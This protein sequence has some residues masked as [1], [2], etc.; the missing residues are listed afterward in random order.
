M[1]LSERWEQWG[2]A[3]RYAL[4]LGHRGDK[5]PCLPQRDPEPNRRS[6]ELSIIRAFYGY[7][8]PDAAENPLLPIAVA[9]KFPVYEN[10]GPAWGVP[11]LPMFLRAFVDTEVKKLWFDLRGLFGPVDKMQAF[12]DLFSRE[13]PPPPEVRDWMRD[14]VFARN[15]VD[16]PNPLLLGRVRDAA[17]LQRAVGI[18][19]DEFQSVMGRG[20]TL[21]DELAAGNLFVADFWLLQHSLLPSTPNQRD[22]RWRRKYLPSP[23]A[24]FC[25]RPGFDPMCD[26]APVAIRI[27]QLNSAPP[28]PL[29]LRSDD[30]RWLTAK[31]YVEVAEFNLQAMSSHI[32]RHHYLAEPFAVTTRRQL[33]PSHPVYVL[34]EPHLA[35]TLA[36]NHS[37]FNLLKQPGSIFDEIY[38]GEL[39]ETRNIMIESYAHWTFGDQALERDLHARGVENGPVDYPYRDDARL[40]MPVIERFVH[41]YLALY[42]Q[43]I[44]DVSS[45]W[46]LQAWA[47]EL[48]AR[49]GGN[50]R[51]LFG[52]ERIATVTELAAVLGQFLF[53]AGPGHAAVHYP[54]T[55]YF[56]YVPAFPG[57][58]FR[59]PPEDGEPMTPTRLLQVLPPIRVG[60]DQFL[61]NQIANYRFDQFGHY[62]RYALG[63]VAAARPLVA[64]LRS[65]LESIEQTIVERNQ[66]RPRPYT[67]LLPS[68]V[69]NSIN[70]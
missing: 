66:R 23:V 12:R 34:L 30:E 28:N 68:L 17:H 64:R 36:V 44:S 10:Y 52:D 69:P 9:G 32:Y 42:Y 39:A 49:D 3:A 27:D 24:L 53:L 62:K 8:P 18:S 11:Y 40:W 7:L 1:A 38:A 15:R 19:D 57:A 50:L 65:D 63:R 70:I 13:L 41:D 31:T 47:R 26:L 2:L 59:P 55:D 45:D 35:Y 22:S 43:R 54:Q 16:G 46:E 33:S 58:A 60:A 56:T 29:Y 61:N 51:G 21:A 48:Q 37:A 25:Q 20:R 14:G 5:Q 67:Y 4:P 6:F